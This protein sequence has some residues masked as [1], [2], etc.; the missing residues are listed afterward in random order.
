MK[1]F[2][3][4]ML[5]VLAL[6]VSAKPIYLVCSTT[7]KNDPP[8]EFSVTIDEETGKVTHQSSKGTTFNADG[9]FTAT[10]VSYKKVNCSSI[11]MTQQFTINRVDLS[12]TSS[13]V[14]SARNVGDATPVTSVGTCSLQAVPERKF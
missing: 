13:I 7:F 9:L 8:K 14:V 1:S 12:V 5:V 3:V 10:E 4:L 11:C 6:P 2:F